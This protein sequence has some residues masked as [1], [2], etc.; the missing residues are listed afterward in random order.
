MK[1]KGNPARRAVLAAAATLALGALSGEAAQA[2][3]AWAAKP[4]REVEGLAQQGN[5]RAE[6]ELCIR[7]GKALGVDQN[8]MEAYAW[9][10][11]AAEQG[12]PV[13]MRNVGLAYY[14]GDAVRKDDK[15]AFAWFQK[16][17]EKGDAP[18]Q[19]DLGICYAQGQGTERDRASAVKWFRRAADQGISKAQERLGLM[20]AQGEG[21]IIDLVEAYK[22]LALAGEADEPNAPAERDRIAKQMSAAQIAEA[23]QAADAWSP[24]SEVTE[25]E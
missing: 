19:Y 6:R 14:D 10:Q 7:Y 25:S 21:T 18:A 1:H 16:A 12:D 4:F 5:V 24:K 13:A 15:Q 8:I 11:K 3:G 2:A 20:L 23:K 17:A 22:W 9:C